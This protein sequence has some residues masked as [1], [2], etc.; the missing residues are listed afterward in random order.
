MSVKSSATLLSSPLPD[1][2]DLPSITVQDIDT[3]PG[4]PVV[5]STDAQVPADALRSALVRL[6]DENAALKEDLDKTRKRVRTLE[7]LD[8][9]IE[10]M[11]KRSFIF[12]CLYCA[13]V[14][15]IVIAHGIDQS[16]F[17]LPESVLQFLVG[18]TATTVIGLVGMVLTGIFV[19]ARKNGRD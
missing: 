10:P 16:G 6:G 19:G 7:I 9:L 1:E 15:G 17:K 11:A 12:M 4:M 2:A 14:A 5:V 18:S 3:A 8:E 13:V